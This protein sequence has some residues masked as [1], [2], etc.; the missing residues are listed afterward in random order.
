MLL[1][2]LLSTASASE[3]PTA[4]QQSIWS[5]PPQ[6]S[7]S[8]SRHNSNVQALCGVGTGLA[9][10]AAALST[11]AF[12]GSGDPWLNR[13]IARANVVLFATPGALLGALSLVPA[14]QLSNAGVRWA[15][16][17]A[18]ASIAAGVGSVFVSAHSRKGTIPDESVFLAAGLAWAA[19]TLALLEVLLANRSAWRQHDPALRL[20]VAPTLN[21][22][23]A[24]M[25]WS[26]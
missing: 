23:S 11:W 6:M 17:L 22:G 4:P 3:A 7:T 1:S 12:V 2:L 19:P 13:G 25:T 9:L 24:T 14:V 20:Q 26:F 18:V 21:G 15:P 10:G 16:S 8:Q 5:A